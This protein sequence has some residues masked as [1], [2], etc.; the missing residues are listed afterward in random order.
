MPAMKNA[1]RIGMLGIILASIVAANGP[2]D[3]VTLKTI[4]YDDLTAAVRL[5]RGKVVVVDF[6]ADYC[7]PCKREFPHL[8]EL[9]RKHAKAG[10]VAVSVSLDDNSEAKRQA[11]GSFLKKQGATFTNYLLDETPTLWQSKLKIDGPPLV[12]VFNRKGELVKRFADEEVDFEKINGL[13][14]ALLIE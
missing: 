8:V 11:V 7:V 10:L 14:A 12:F 5:S 13:V 9:Q 6:W 2:A 4:K 1:T 3:A